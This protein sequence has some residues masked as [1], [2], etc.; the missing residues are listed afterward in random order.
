VTNGVTSL[1][2]P[3]LDHQGTVRHVVD[4]ATGRIVAGFDY[5]PYGEVV[6]ESGD[7]AAI[8]AVPFR[9]QTKYCDRES[10]L[11]YFGHRYYVPSTGKWLTRDPLGE[12]G[13]LNLTQS[14][15]G[16]P[17]NG[18]DA[19]GLVNVVVSGTDGTRF[20]SKDV[21]N[22]KSVTSYFDFAG[23]YYFG[24]KNF[25]SVGS[26]MTA[27]GTFLRKTWT[28]PFS[29]V[30]DLVRPVFNNPLHP[31]DY[32]CNFASGEATTVKNLARPNFYTHDVQSNGGKIKDMIVESQDDRDVLMGHSQG[33]ALISYGLLEAS[34]SQTVKRNK[35]IKLVLMAPKMGADWLEGSLAEIK[36]N[37]P[38][39]KVDVL[40]IGNRWDNSIPCG[41]KWGY[42]A[43]S[44]PLTKRVETQ[45]SDGATSVE[46]VP[47]E[48]VHYG[49]GFPLNR[50]SA[51]WTTY[52][53]ENQK[54]P[55][56][57]FLHTGLFPD[58]VGAISELSDRTS[59]TL[60]N[61]ILTFI[62]P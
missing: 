13:G 3:V 49:R 55:H 39:W 8:E 19:L 38:G 54:D 18:V 14:F 48:G 15:G 37:Q 35:T 5:T 11:L 53:F 2:L 36:K 16:D 21:S 9:F 24:E 50:K 56:S 28:M 12:E 25:K 7:P 20:F 44:D 46:I 62:Q 34:R 17:V 30:S 4:A 51:Y 33:V 59:V 10:G 22:D 42:F 1:Y 23:V 57:S 47:R 29:L 61:R 60:R 6:A 26:F 41:T 32:V 52:E 58:A 27:G 43:E 45:D 31:I 40:I